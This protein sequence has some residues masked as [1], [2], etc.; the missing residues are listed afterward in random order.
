MLEKKSPDF[1]SISYPMG[2][3]KKKMAPTAIAV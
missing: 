3:F 2:G 1:M